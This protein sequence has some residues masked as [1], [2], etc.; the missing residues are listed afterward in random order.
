MGPEP[1][2]SRTSFWQPYQ[3]HPES[4]YIGYETNDPTY[5]IVDG[6]ITC[7]SSTGYRY[8]DA[9]LFAYSAVAP[10]AAG[11]G[12][13][14]RTTYPSFGN[15]SYGSRE[16]ENQFTITNESEYAISGELLD[17]VGRASGW[18]YG[19]VEQT[20]VDVRS[21]DTGAVYV[22]QDI[23]SAAAEPG[24]SGAPVFRFEYS[25]DVTAIG[26]LRGWNET[27]AGFSVSGLGA[28][29]YEMGYVPVYH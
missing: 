26:L 3:S 2:Q 7:P 5:W 21:E 12:K 11:Q 13:I 24:D 16:I 18:T 19:Y 25:Y 22:C 14:W 9:A 8:S 28:I 23:V 6:A 20:C 15:G 17:K 10:G 27:F 4:A 1:I 29:W